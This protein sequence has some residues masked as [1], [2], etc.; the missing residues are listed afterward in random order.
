MPLP[1]S[2]T[3]MSIA[4]SGYS[5]LWSA[6][7][8]VPMVTVPPPGIASR[9]LIARFSSAS[10]SWVLSPTTTAPGRLQIRG[11]ADIGAER[12]AQRSSMLVIIGSTGTV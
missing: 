4:P 7:G 6:A 2:R 8:A 3:T 5:S 11:D 12:P 10:S 9:A 1:L